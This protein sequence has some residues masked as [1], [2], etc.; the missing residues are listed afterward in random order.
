MNKINIRIVGASGRMGQSLIQEISLDK[1]LVL[2]AAID[3]K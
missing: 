3:H 1:E 2:T